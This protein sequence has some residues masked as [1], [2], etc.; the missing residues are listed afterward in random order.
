MVI[1]TFW[2]KK[3]HGICHFY[4]GTLGKI[5][6]LMF[7]SWSHSLLP[8]HPI[9]VAE[10]MRMHEFRALFGIILMHLRAFSGGFSATE[11][12]LQIPSLKCKERRREGTWEVVPSETQHV[13]K[14]KHWLLFSLQ[15]D[16]Y[17]AVL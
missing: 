12:H 7:E 8:F 6:C 11:I 9:S 4:K 16:L 1:R 2:C 17:A 5:T 10:Q 3:F 15:C 13:L 14:S